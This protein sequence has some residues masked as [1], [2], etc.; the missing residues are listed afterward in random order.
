MAQSTPISISVKARDW[1]PRSAAA[2][3]CDRYEA[4]LMENDLDAMDAL[5]WDDPLTLRY[6][7]GENLHGIGEIRAFRKARTGGSPPRTVLRREIVTFGTDL[8]T[9]NLEFQ[10][11]GG[12]KIGRQS[13]T[14]LR[15]ETGWKVASAH[16][17]LMADGS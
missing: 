3:T 5:F 6:G 12:T 15:T 11:Q 13:Q 14:W 16:V 10:R 2:L 17:S 9:C 4:A 7:V 8:G 1:S